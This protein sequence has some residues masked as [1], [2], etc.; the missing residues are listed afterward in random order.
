MVF[1][2]SGNSTRSRILLDAME[3]I[4]SFIASNHRLDSLQFMAVLMP[5]FKQ[6][7][8]IILIGSI[9]FSFYGNDVGNLFNE[10]K[11][12]YNSLEKV[13]LILTFIGC[14]SS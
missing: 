10:R 3:F 8:I 9:T 1:A 14:L 12:S 5:T 11:F 2:P 7:L 13:P 6:S 4:S